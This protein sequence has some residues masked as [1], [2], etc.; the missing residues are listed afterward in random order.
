MLP[1]LSR[2]K[3]IFARAS[4]HTEICTPQVDTIP[5]SA[6]ITSISKKRNGSKK[7]ITFAP[8]MTSA[9]NR[10]QTPVG[11]LHTLRL[12]FF[13]VPCVHCGCVI[14]P[15]RAEMSGPWRY[16]EYMLCTISQRSNR[17]GP[18]PHRAKQHRS[19]HT[20]QNHRL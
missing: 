9:K 17:A 19:G 1:S 5:D 18:N 11:E 16:N 14:V 6:K 8:H 10:A 3:E 12:P 7:N 4:R 2:F 13:R 15:S 20:D